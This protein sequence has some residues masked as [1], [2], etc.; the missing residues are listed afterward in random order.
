M[1]VLILKLLRCCFCT[2]CFDA[3]KYNNQIITADT[4]IPEPVPL[5][6]CWLVKASPSDTTGYIHIKFRNTSDVFYQI[7]TRIDE[8]E[9]V[10]TPCLYGNFSS[11][12]FA[13][14]DR[15]SL[16]IN[17]G[18]V[19]FPEIQFD[20]YFTT[21][22]RVYL[23]FRTQAKEGYD[24]WTSWQNEVLNAQNPIFPANTNLK[25]NIN[26]GIGIWCGYGTYNYRIETH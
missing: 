9:T 25:S 5:D 3:H 16:Q 19:L 15:V 7:A 21:G 18:P 1:P 2:K 20:T 24:F 6:S 12:Q 17:K 11:A 14:N 22:N 26:G 4:Y 13:K 10:F 8:R 23:K